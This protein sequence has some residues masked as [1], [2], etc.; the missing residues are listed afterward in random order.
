[1]TINRKFFFETARMRLFAGSLKTGQVDGMGQILDLWET[2][3]A[4]QDDRWL[5]YMLA[6]AYHE[7]ARTM[8]PV[9]ETL[10]TTDEDAIRVLENAWARGQLPWVSNPYWRRDENGKTWLGRGL[11]QLTHFDNYKEMSDVLGIDLVTDPSVAMNMEVALQIMFVGMERGSFTKAHLAQF[12]N[13]PKEDW[14]NARR[15]INKLDKALQI[16]DYGRA[17]YS[18]ISYT[19]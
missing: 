14:V 5:A 9:R 3:R 4:G 2:T 1:M 17:F 6:T 8:Q 15:I 16:A 18:C 12:F 19:T 11:V 10:R 7:T 13:G